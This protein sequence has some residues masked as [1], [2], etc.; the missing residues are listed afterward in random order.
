MSE[1]SDP[2]APP[3]PYGAAPDAEVDLELGDGYQL[4]PKREPALETPSRP[5]AA[6]RA[7]AAPPRVVVGEGLS[8]AE[9]Q[10]G[11]RRQYWTFTRIPVLLILGWFT[12][13][14]LALDAQWVFIDGV[15]TLF[16][17]AGHV[18]F[19]WGGDTIYF[20][21]GT[22]GQLLWPLGLGL[23]FIFKRRERFSATVCAWWFG[24]NF[25][26]IARYMDD[27][28]VEELP[29]VGGNIHDWNHLFTK[30]HMIRKARDVADVVRVL[31]IIL[32]LGALA[33][34]LY[35]TLKPTEKELAEGFTA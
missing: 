12:L 30:W 19:R 18:L 28:P 4:Q 34:L 25:L 16:H 32:M 17:E 31:G 27:A 20:M 11:L 23:Y 21:G 15:N 8:Y 33:Y 3:D 10:A 22:L 26:N 9:K 24:E 7:P 29:L 5:S 35:M 6:P 14:H 1:G 2:F 13:S